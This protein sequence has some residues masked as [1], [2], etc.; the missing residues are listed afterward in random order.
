MDGGGALVCV[1]I[2]LVGFQAVYFG[3]SILFVG[4]KMV[5]LGFFF[6]LC[7]TSNGG[8]LESC[9]GPAHVFVRYIMFASCLSTIACDTCQLLLLLLLLRLLLQS[10]LTLSADTN[11]TKFNTCTGTLILVLVP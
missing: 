11:S 9:W 10:I 1:S 4:F 7:W 3:V 6:L 8:L 2:L 5:Y